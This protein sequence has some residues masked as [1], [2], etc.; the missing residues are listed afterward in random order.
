MK[1]NFEL[2]M[3]KQIDQLNLNL[4]NL[5]DFYDFVIFNGLN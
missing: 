4:N 3:I 2:C 5:N 1:P